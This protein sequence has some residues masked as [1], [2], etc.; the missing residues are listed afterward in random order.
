[1]ILQISHFNYNVKYLP[2]KDNLRVEADCLSQNPVLESHEATSELK[3]VNFNNVNDI[4]EDQKI[5]FQNF[6]SELNVINKD[7]ILFTKCKDKNKI[8]ISDEFAKE[9][10]KKTHLKFGHIGS[11]QIE[12]TILPFFYNVNLV[13]LI[14]EFCKICPVCIKNKSC[15]PSKYGHLSH[16]GPAK[17][18][19]EIM[20][21][22]TIGG[23]SGNNSKKRHIHLLVNHFSRYAYAVTSSTQKAPDFI[24]LI[25]LALNIKNKIS[26]LLADQYAGI[27]S[28]SFKRFL[29]QK[30]ICLLFT[31]VD[32]AFSNGLNERLNQTLVNRPRCKINESENNKKRPWPIL[33]N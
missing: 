1:M 24:K 12:L 8:I 17:E 20:S 9:L 15:V 21:L 4:L 27:N 19:F 29:Q 32:C 31:A 14:S 5:A 33:L 25:N 23:F 26:N 3:V 11:K 10:I 6:S 18:S 30:N 22:D 2:G 16:L 13:R 28:N 7:N